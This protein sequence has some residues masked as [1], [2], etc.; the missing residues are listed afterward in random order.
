MK[1]A[2]QLWAGLSVE[3]SVKLEQDSETGAVAMVA[4]IDG[5]PL[6]EEMLQWALQYGFRQGIRDAGAA[7]KTDSE[8]NAL[9]EKRIVAIQTG[10]MRQGSGGGKVT[11][12]LQREVRALAEAEVRAATENP[13]NAEWVAK[14]RAAKGLSLSDL[15]KEMLKPY[16]E[17]HKERLEAKAKAIIAERAV[18]VEELDIAI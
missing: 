18:E 9:A 4:A 7:G 17:K 3:V 2:V 1:F 6:S 12:P 13:A 5:R 11:D 8:R 10:T 16:I 14:N 15:R